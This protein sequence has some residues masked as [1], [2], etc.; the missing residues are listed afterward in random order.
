MIPEVVSVMWRIPKPTVYLE[1]DISVSHDVHDFHE[2]PPDK[3]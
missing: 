2:C 3:Q 1:S